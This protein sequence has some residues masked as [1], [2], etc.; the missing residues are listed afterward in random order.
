MYFRQN[1]W[2]IKEGE[3]ING[4]VGETLSPNSDEKEE[5]L[6]GRL[7]VGM[8][9]GHRYREGLKVIMDKDVEDEVNGYK[10]QGYKY[11]KGWS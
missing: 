7:K 3:A 5:A 2:G 11:P 1:L 6:K 10:N 8:W 9:Q 4:E